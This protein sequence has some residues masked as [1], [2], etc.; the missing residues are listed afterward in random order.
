MEFLEW[1]AGT[2]VVAGIQACG[3][4]AIVMYLVAPW[5]YSSVSEALLD[6]PR[7]S[8]NRRDKEAT[9]YLYWFLLPLAVPACIAG[10]LASALSLLTLKP[11][12]LLL[13]KIIGR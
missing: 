7:W 13:M 12:L 6:L 10:G 8:L 1:A 4:F 3:F 5:V 11:F 9:G 2:Y